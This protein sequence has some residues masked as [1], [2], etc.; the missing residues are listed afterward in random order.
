MKAKK[1]FI[2]L[3]FLACFNVYSQNTLKGCYKKFS[4]EFI[5][6][7]KEHKIT[8]TENDS[9]LFH[10]TFYD[11]F[12]Y[13]ISACSDVDESNLLIV[14]YDMKDN[15][16][17]SNEFYNFAQSWDFQFKSTMECKIKIKIIGTKFKKGTVYLLTGYKI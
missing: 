7:E 9:A 10:L 13:R 14:L 12:T 5:I 15:I 3:L 17:F 11:S 4:S 8:I 1:L 2:L 16:L 6:S